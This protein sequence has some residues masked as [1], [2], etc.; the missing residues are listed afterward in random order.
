M[1]GSSDG[2]CQ[3]DTAHLIPANWMGTSQP[4]RLVNLVA[5]IVSL[6]WI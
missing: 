4:I 6:Y 5:S 1:P 2:G 3:F